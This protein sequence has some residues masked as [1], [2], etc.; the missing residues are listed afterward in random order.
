LHCWQVALVEQLLEE[1]WQGPWAAVLNPGWF[2]ADAAAVPQPYQAL[3]ASWEAA[4]SLTIT[5]TQVCVR[6]WWVV[7]QPNTRQRVD[8]HRS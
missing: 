5:A 3:V 4:Y 8:T 1:A 2:S 6:V 7:L